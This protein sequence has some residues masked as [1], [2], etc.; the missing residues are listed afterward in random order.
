MP[1]EPL[2]SSQ[3]WSWRSSEVWC[4][5][6]C[7]KDLLPQA[8][9]AAGFQFTWRSKM[10][11]PSLMW[12]SLGRYQGKLGNAILLLCHTLD[13][14]VPNW[15]FFSSLLFGCYFFQG[16]NVLTLLLLTFLC[17]CFTTVNP[18]QLQAPSLRG[19]QMNHLK[20][21]GDK[22]FQM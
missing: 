4:S 2:R 7:T 10:L 15:N 13:R 19:A 11:S 5:S 8:E 12:E 3:E 9:K 20:A 17:C 18:F 6:C 22:G 16:G 14:L 1:F 21:V